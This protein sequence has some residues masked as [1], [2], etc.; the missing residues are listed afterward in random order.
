VRER[1]RERERQL[2]LEA[3]KLRGMEGNFYSK[4]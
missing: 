4:Q 3:I 2:G 1:E